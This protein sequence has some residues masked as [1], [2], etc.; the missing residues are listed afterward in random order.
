MVS[1]IELNKY[2]DKLHLRTFGKI[3]KHVVLDYGDQVSKVQLKR[4]L[5]KRVKDSR[6]AIVRNKRYMNIVFSDH[7]YGYVMDLLVNK[8]SFKPRYWFV[9]VNIN[10]RY[11]F[12]YPLNNKDKTSVLNVLK[13]FVKDTKVFSLTGD[14]EGAFSAND[15]VKFLT[16][17]HVS[18]RIVKEQNHGA[19]S[20]IDRFIRTLRDMNIPT[21]KTHRESIDEKYV[22]F[23][24]KRM[25]K[26]V[27]IYNDTYHS[28][29]G[30]K[31]IEMQNDVKLEDKYIKKMLLKHM[32]KIKDD[33]YLLNEGEYV[34]VVLDKDAMEKRRYKVSREVYKVVGREGQLFIIS[35]KDGSTRLVPRWKLISVGMEI[36]DNMKF[37]STIVG[38]EKGVL[39]RIVDWGNKDK[40]KYKVEFEMP[41]GSVYK[42]VIPISFVRGKYPQMETK[43]EKEFRER[44]GE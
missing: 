12:A 13:M 28:S 35:A 3:W 9:F 14:D 4:V 25:G 10:T 18:L 29:I 11:A 39:K 17:K 21:E 8:S 34:R 6:K 16:D 42:D 24:V 27:K 41:D 33:G 37:A 22:N 43:L 19:L 2:I 23:S 5:K 7:P 32:Q 26:L 15:V 20:I 44:I 38:V 30:M 31:P 1:D 36:P 40:T